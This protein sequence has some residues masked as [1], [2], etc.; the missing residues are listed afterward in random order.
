M[1]TLLFCISN[2]PKNK[3]KS[4]FAKKKIYISRENAL[5]MKTYKKTNEKRV[6]EQT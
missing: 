4:T 1:D 6:I 5:T 2:I 3:I